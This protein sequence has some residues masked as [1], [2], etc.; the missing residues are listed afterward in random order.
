MNKNILKISPAKAHIMRIRINE[1]GLKTPEW[2][3]NLSDAELAAC[4]N[5][6]GSDH[7]PKAIRRVLTWLLGFAPEAILIHDAEFQY[8]KRFLPLD[9]YSQQNFHAANRRLGEN[10][11]TMA[12]LSKPWY[13][14]I[15]YWEVFVA[16]HARYVCDDWGYD[17]WIV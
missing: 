8:T 15:R 3:D 4:Y 5:G 12:K 11:V 16:R 1:I 9:Y 14:L 6:A 13:S 7:T 2:F 10:A 17:E